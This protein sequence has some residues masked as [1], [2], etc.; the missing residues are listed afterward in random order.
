[1]GWVESPPYFCAATETARDVCTEYIEKEVGTLHRHKFDKYV[2]GDPEFKALPVSGISA[3]EFLYTVGVYVDDFMSCVIPI[4]QEQ[5][6]HVST[7]V[8]TGI[9]DVFP[10]DA[11][12]SNDPISEK[13]TET[14]RGTIL[15][16]E[17]TSWL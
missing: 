14:A 9:H 17:N 3:N 13:K 8:M 10:T 7:A 16:T 2:G 15:H 4:S 5:L 6:R 11:D 1:M 12:D